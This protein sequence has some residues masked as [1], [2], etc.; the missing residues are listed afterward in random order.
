MTLKELYEIVDGL[1]PF[2]LSAEMTERFGY[3]DN[4]GLL[5]ECGKTANRVLFSLD[6]SGRA[7]DEA[8]RMG[9][10]AIVTHHPVIWDPVLR[11]GG[12]SQPLLARCIRNRISVISA[13][14]NLDAAEGGID[15]SLMNALGGTKALAVHEKLSSGGYGR[16]FNV[17]ERPME[18]FAAHAA[19]ELSAVRYAV[20]GE[21]RVKRVASFCG[22]GFS[23][24]SIA[25]AAE[26]GADTVVSSDGKHHVILEAVERGMNVLLF[27][28]YASENY[29]FARFAERACAALN[30]GGAEVGVFTDER[31]L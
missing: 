27:S 10:D 18:A 5:L 25:F 30:A 16:V 7:L 12:E 13:H 6:L 15:E 2:A 17:E 29:G 9:A 19:R 8:E 3:R 11:I 4:S 14:L 21:K 26:H 28:H 20:Y 31:F 22:G 24:D 23:P 1:A